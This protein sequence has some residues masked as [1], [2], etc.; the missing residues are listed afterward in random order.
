MYYKTEHFLPI[1][2]SNFLKT[3]FNNMST[4]YLILVLLITWNIFLMRRHF[5]ACL[6]CGHVNV[7]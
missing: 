5:D 4:F 1:V 2:N 6:V 7:K 3:F